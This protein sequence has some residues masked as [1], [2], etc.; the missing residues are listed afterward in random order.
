[1][2]ELIYIRSQLEK[3]YNLQHTNNT[4]SEVRIHSTAHYTCILSQ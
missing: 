1:M 4:E 2:K 3:I